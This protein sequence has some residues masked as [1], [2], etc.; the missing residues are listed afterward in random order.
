MQIEDHPTQG[1]I[2]K[3][4]E[5]RGN[6]SDPAQLMRSGNFYPQTFLGARSLE[7]ATKLKKLILIFKHNNRDIIQYVEVEI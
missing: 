6:F 7:R 1:E 5:E 4:N 2:E 3:Q